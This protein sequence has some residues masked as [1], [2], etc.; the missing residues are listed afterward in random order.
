VTSIWG[1]PKNPE[2]HAKQIMRKVEGCTGGRT[3]LE[4]EE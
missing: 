1:T 4:D 3:P 2:T